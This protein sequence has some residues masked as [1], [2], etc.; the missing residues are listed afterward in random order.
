MSDA[1]RKI[2]GFSNSDS[3]LSYGILTVKSGETIYEGEIVVVLTATPTV[4]E[5]GGD[6]ANALLATVALQ[7]GAAGEKI[8]CAHP[9]SGRE[10]GPYTYTTGSVTNAV[11][12]KRMFADG[13]AEVD[14]KSGTSNAVPLG[15]CT[16]PDP[17]APTTKVFVALHQ[18]DA[19]A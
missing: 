9:M 11:I 16:R 8:R 1:V 7:G 15:Y 2:E 14:I 19:T 3:P 18:E 4:V 10:Y 6:T 17:D 12:G 13:S 5:K